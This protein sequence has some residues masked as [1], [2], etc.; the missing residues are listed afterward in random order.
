MSKINGYFFLSINSDYKTYKNV[1][2]IATGQGDY[3]TGFW[4]DYP[5]FKE[6][7]KTIAT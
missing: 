2:E 3:T 6:N 5:G 4:L 7:Y 1:R